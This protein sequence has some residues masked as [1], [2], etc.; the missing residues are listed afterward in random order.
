M[1][2]HTFGRRLGALTIEMYNLIRTRKSWRPIRSM[3][4]MDFESYSMLQYHNC[5]DYINN[6]NM[7]YSFLDERRFINYAY[8]QVAQAFGC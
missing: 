7:L 5:Q 2:R 8:H 4:E 6:I 1:R 3:I